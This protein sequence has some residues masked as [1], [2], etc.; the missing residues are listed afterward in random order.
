MIVQRLRKDYEFAFLF[1]SDPFE[2]S[3]EVV[4]MPLVCLTRTQKEGLDRENKVANKNYSH[5]NGLN[6]LFTE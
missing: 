6:G 5:A 4:R 1:S 2:T 3:K